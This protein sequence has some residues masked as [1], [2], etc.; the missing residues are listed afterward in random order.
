M[1]SKPHEVWLRASSRDHLRRLY[2][3]LQEGM[4]VRAGHYADVTGSL[5]SDGMFQVTIYSQKGDD[6]RAVLQKMERKGLVKI[7]TVDIAHF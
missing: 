3:I 1:T 7:T 2:D 5:A 6:L 4:K